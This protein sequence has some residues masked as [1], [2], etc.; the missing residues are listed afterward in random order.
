MHKKIKSRKYRKI[1]RKTKEKYKLTLEE[2]RELDP[3]GAKTEV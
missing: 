2:M 3:E 1:L